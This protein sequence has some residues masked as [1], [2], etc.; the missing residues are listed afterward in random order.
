MLGTAVAGGLSPICNFSK[1][2]MME[3]KFENAVFTKK[4]NEIG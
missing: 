1:N 3:D 4:S 2:S